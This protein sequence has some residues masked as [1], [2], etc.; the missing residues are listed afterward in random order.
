[1]T[2]RQYA[3]LKLGYNRHKKKNKKISIGPTQKHVLQF[4]LVFK[5]VKICV[6]L[7]IFYR[8][9]FKFYIFLLQYRNMTIFLFINKNNV[10]IS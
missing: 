9:L 3:E 5:Y 2:I 10:I 8:L 7:Y 6:S 4:F 1:M